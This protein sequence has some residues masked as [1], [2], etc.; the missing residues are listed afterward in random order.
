M[1]RLIT[2]KYPSKCPACSGSIGE[3]ERVAWA[4]GEKARHPHC[5]GYLQCPYC[6]GAGCPSCRHKG[7]RLRSEMSAED[8]DQY[9][10]VNR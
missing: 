5:A 3:G 2:A 8:L 4:K 9:R 10:H 6:Y 1:K 7:Y